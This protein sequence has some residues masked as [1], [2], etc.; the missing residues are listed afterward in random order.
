[1]TYPTSLALGVK[2]TID[3]LFLG[4]P[5]TSL[6]CWAHVE[7]GLVA[8]DSTFDTLFPE[9]SLD[10]TCISAGQGNA[11]ITANYTSDTQM[12]TMETEQKINL[13]AGIDCVGDSSGTFTSN[14]MVDLSLLG[15]TQPEAANV[16]DWCDEPVSLWV[17]TAEACIRIDPQANTVLDAIPQTANTFDAVPIKAPGP[18]IGPEFGMIANGFGIGGAYSFDEASCSSFPGLFIVDSHTDIIQIAQDPS[19]GAVG[20]STF[21]RVSLFSL[22][23][24]LGGY[25]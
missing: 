8:D 2:G 19:L 3:L 4:S 16:A 20:A 21:A 10:V 11:I 17:G 7:T 1:M 6:Q 14:L 22:D 18:G 15:Y 5:L 25:D 13:H 12:G 23:P 24:V 9:T